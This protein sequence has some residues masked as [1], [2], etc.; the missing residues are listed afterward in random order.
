ML[1]EQTR[2]ETSL[3]ARETCGFGGLTEHFHLFS[4]EYPS[5][6]PQN[7][8]YKAAQMSDPEKADLFLYNLRVAVAAEA[9]LI[10]HEDVQ[11]SIRI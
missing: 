2:S 4:E 1:V 7:I 3:L 9:R 10:S 11:V 6:F 5:T 8:T